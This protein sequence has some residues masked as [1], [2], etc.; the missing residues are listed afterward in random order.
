MITTRVITEPTLSPTSG[1]SRSTTT[2][3]SVFS[4]YKASES[5]IDTTKVIEFSTTAENDDSFIFVSNSSIIFEQVTS[6]SMNQDNKTFNPGARNV[7][8]GTATIQLVTEE[9][10]SLFSNW[11]TNNN[12]S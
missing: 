12:F 3:A 4:T 1:S 9:S 7:L 6:L 10:V 5:D 2:I 11:I 8:K